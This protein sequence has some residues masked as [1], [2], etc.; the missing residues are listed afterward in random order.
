VH[1]GKWSAKQ[2]E[3]FLEDHNKLI[4][5]AHWQTH[6][7]ADPTGKWDYI[8][9]AENGY[10]TGYDVNRAGITRGGHVDN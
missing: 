6:C 2:L 9:T 1:S 8:C 3:T 10:R 4:A 5:P 7:V